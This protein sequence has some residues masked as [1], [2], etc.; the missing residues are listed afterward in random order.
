MR[1]YALQTH[2]IRSESGG[3]KQQEGRS[4]TH[5][6]GSQLYFFR[7]LN[8]NNLDSSSCPTPSP[9]TV[10]LLPPHSADIQHSSGHVR[11]VSLC[12]SVTRPVTLWN[13]VKVS[14]GYTTGRAAT[15]CSTASVS[16]A[17]HNDWYLSGSHLTYGKCQR[18]S[19]PL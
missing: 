9:L 17:S 16:G 13:T 14:A 10:K 19:F 12:T 1:A 11:P 6:Q 5:Q 4:E 2:L 18:K 15:S 8:F 7:F 3:R